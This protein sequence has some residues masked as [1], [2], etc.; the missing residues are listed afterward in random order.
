MPKATRPLSGAAKDKYF[1]ELFGAELPKEAADRLLQLCKR[2]ISQLR[3]REPIPSRSP[4]KAS[5][6][7][8]AAT[9]PEARPADQKPAAEPEAID[10][11][12]P[13]A[14]SLVSFYRR[15]GR[16]AL[17]SR[18]NGITSVAHLRKLAEA[19]HVMI[20]PEITDADALRTAIVEGTEQRLADRRAAAS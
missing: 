13:Y 19:Q 11:F 16:D 5:A 10:T 4:A 7:E 14:F 17:M 15:S 8:P 3:V 6:P 20:G 1:R 9:A 12:D 18:L 2:E